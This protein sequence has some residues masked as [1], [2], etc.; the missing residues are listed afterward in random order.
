LLINC[1]KTSVCGLNCIFGST[2]TSK[3]KSDIADVSTQPL[4]KIKNTC[5]NFAFAEK[6]DIFTK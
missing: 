3:G 6:N 1:C 2:E 4:K 5:S